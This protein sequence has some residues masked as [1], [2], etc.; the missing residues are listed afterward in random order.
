MGEVFATV[1]GEGSLNLE[2]E[3]PAVVSRAVEAAVSSAL[4]RRALT[5]DTKSRSTRASTLFPR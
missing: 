3:D 1:S 4:A 2:G 5:E